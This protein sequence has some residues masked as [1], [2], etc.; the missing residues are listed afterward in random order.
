MS[1]YISSAICKST[2]GHLYKLFVNQMHSRVHGYFLFNRIVNI[3]NILPSCYLNTNIVSC[4]KSKLEQFNFS[5]YT[6]GRA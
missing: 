3:W 5:S 1:D 6:L 2:R 4:F